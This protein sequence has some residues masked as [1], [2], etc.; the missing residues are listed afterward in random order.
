MYLDKATISIKAGNGGD[1]VV[2]FHREKYVANGGPDGG[3][4]GNGGSI[5]FVASDKVNT[6]NNFMYEKKF[7]APNGQNGS[8]KFCYGKK[9]DDLRIIVPC[10]T[11]IKDVESG[12][13]LADMYEDG[14]EYICL[15]GGRGGKG[16]AFFKSPTRQAPHFSQ[17][18]EQTKKYDVILE[19]KTIADVALVGKPNVGK[20]TLLSVIS[21][22]RPKI[23]DYN[24]TTLHPNLGVVKYYDN[25]FVVADIPGLIEGASDGAGLGHE[26]LAHIERTRLLVHVIDI[27]GYY[28]NIP[29]DDFNMINNELKLYSQ[30]LSKLPQIVVFTKTDLINDLDQRIDEFKNTTNFDG[31]IIAISSI[32]HNNVDVLIKTIYD[33]LQTLPK[34]KPI[35]VEKHELHVEDITSL[36]I[37]KIDNNTY[38]VSGGYIQNLQRGIVFTDTASNGYFQYRLEKDGIMDKIREAGAKEGDTICMGNLEFELVD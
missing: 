23:A 1:G 2:S 28:G 4:G 3:D 9:G 14:L 10:G 22:A 5:I 37:E 16:N 20:S 31:E 32:T 29:S 11:V 26:F 38:R 13:V 19:L 25:N 15:K 24:F 35:E 18:G 30:H 27:S 21:N 8:G 7:F 36:N 17:L 12:K 6:L 34:P 33:K